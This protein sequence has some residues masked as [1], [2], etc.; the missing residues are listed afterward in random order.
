MKKIREIYGFGSV[1]WTEE[2]LLNGILDDIDKLKGKA[3][4]IDYNWKFEK[5]QLILPEIA[6][7]GLNFTITPIK[8]KTC[9]NLF[10]QID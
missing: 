4:K 6:K 8:D 5:V 3:S 2:D 7:L 1:K 9:V 10:I